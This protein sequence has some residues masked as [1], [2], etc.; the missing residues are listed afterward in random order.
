MADTSLIFTIAAQ[1]R[2]LN[3]RLWEL[4]AKPGVLTDEEWAY[5]ETLENEEAADVDL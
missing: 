1:V 3:T 4:L 5:I 2:P